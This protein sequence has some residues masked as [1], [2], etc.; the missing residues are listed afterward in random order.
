[1]NAVYPNVDGKRDIPDYTEMFV[2]W[3]WRYYEETGDRSLLADAYPVMR[4][5][6]GYVLR[7]VPDTGATA[8]LVTNLAGGGGPYQYGIIDWPSPGRYGYDMS[9]AARTTINVQGVDVLRGVALAARAL[10]RPASEAEPFEQRAERLAAAINARLRRP[11]GIYIDG[12]LA[13]G[14]PSTH[15]SQHANSYAVAYGVA[16]RESYPRIAAYIAGLGMK[17]GPMTAHWLLQ[18]LSDADRPDAVLAR[19][20]D[21]TSDGWANILARGGTFTWEQWNPV[22]SESYSHG[23]G[24]QAAVD[25]LSTMLGFRVASPGA[26]T[27]D[28]VPPRVGLE[29]ARGTVHT[30]RGAVTIDWRR[31]PAGLLLRVDVPANVRARVLLPAGAGATYSASGEGAPT[32]RGTEDGRT[33]Y[34]VGSGRSTFAPARGGA[35]SR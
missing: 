22:Q 25:V 3:V 15:A 20:T 27:V 34:E 16:P 26:A 17:Q 9:A 19:L 12:L 21:R 5:I 7:H 11:D 30:Q 31:Q 1:V 35:G 10:G 23:W 14:S 8:G 4:N 2:D 24:A 29:Y 13:D 28:I 18:A 6:A 33:V 32:L